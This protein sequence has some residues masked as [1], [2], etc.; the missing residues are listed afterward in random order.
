[1]QQIVIFQAE[2]PYGSACDEVRYL[3]ANCENLPAGLSGI[4]APGSFERFERIEGCENGLSKPKFP[5]GTPYLPLAMIN[6]R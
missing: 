3:I 4:P 6:I 5:Y 2:S 1:M